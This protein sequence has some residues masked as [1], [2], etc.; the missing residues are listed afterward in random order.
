MA[1]VPTADFARIPELGREAIGHRVSL[2]GLTYVPVATQAGGR[3]GRPVM[4]RSMFIL[5]S[6][7]TVPPLHRRGRSRG[8]GPFHDEVRRGRE[9]G[10]ID[11]RLLD[12]VP[13]DWTGWTG[14]GVELKVRDGPALAGWPHVPGVTAWPVG[15]RERYD[16][17]SGIGIRLPAFREPRDWFGRRPREQ[18]EAWGPAPAVQE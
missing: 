7:P 9:L 10:T 16:S 17:C 14:E 13:P 3:I 11:G 4:S 5:L 2:T 6:P 15:S 8:P 12:Q 1:V 18:V